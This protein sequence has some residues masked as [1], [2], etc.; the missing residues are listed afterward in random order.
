MARMARL[1]VPG[2]PHHVTQRG[3]RRQDVFLVEDDYG[4]YIRLLGE[5]SRARGLDIWAYCL[6]PNHVHL[7]CVPRTADAL[8]A[9]VAE[10]HRRF[11]LHVNT[12]E[13]WRGHLWQERFHSFAMD[14]AHLYQAVRYVELNPVRAGLVKRPRDWRWSSARARLGGRDDPLLAP[15][16]PLE[17]FGDW[18]AYLRGGLD[19]ET[20]ARLRLNSRTGRPL[21]SDDFIRDLERRTGRT[22]KPQKR[23]PKGKSE[24]SENN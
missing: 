22:L 24:D 4:V 20:L 18:R 3:N 16:R 21:G 5:N 1:V 12:R 19:D 2:V 7:V 8:R 14:E 13:D 23:G 10:T 11:T 6:M 9:A 15:A 17:E